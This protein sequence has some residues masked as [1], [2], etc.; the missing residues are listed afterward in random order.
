MALRDRV[1]RRQPSWLYQVG[2]SR[3]LYL[4][5]TMGSCG[6]MSGPL[7]EELVRQVAA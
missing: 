1:T 7:T 5:Y 6:Q 3:V 2:L 4:T